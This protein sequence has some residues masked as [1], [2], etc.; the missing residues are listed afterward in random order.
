MRVV[1]FGLILLTS[2][3]LAKEGSSVLYLLQAEEWAQAFEAYDQRKITLG[4]HDFDQLQQM[5]LA[6]LEKSARS[7][8]PTEQ[9]TSLFGSSIAG[10][11]ASIDILE[12]GI[13]SP[14][15]ETQMAALQFLGHLQDDRCEELFT[16][17]MSSD[18]FFTRMEAAHQLCLR[19][20]HTA[21]GQIESLMYKVPPPMRSFF[22]PFFA[23]LGTHDAIVLLKGMMDDPLHIVRVEA[24][25]SAAR[26]GR[27]D[28]LPAIRRLATHLNTAEQEACAFAFGTLK[29][30]Q[31]IPLLQ[32]LK[33]SHS[34]GVQLASLLA[35]FK[36]G[37]V[38]AKKEIETRA[39]EHD[40]FAIALLGEIPGSEGK[41]RPLLYSSD[42]QVRFNATL[43]L[44]QRKDPTVIPS[45]MSFLIRDSRD[46][47][48]Q[49]QFSLGNSLMA[50]KTIPSAK[51]HAKESPY[52]IF[53]LSLNL[54]EHLLQDALELPPEAFLKVA[55]SLFESK[56]TDLIPR[57]I[58]LMENLQ[59]EEAIALLKEGAQLTGA[60]LTRS[61]C[62][63]ALYRVTKEEIYKS[64][65]LQW[66]SLKQQTEIIRFRPQLPWTV[67]FSDQRTPFEL[68]PEENSRLLID[69][70]QTLA[71]SQ[72][73]DAID[74]LLEALRKGNSSN[75]PLLAGLLIQAIQ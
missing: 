2:P 46:L 65:L 56:Q 44:L 29:D 8:S 68:T 51:Q 61:Y 32:R 15:P 48:F 50:W 34:P 49:P 7:S 21:T 14:H 75:R 9:L 20:A 30:A 26:F 55:R 24:I 36:L 45:L 59:T 66:I 42:P 47:G 3:L 37:D 25:L 74:I 13:T 64:A 73:A 28:L 63:L 18:F 41:L 10:V 72:E 27:D 4:K 62:H 1:F 53:T 40:L 12:A 6:I 57:L 5:A 43:A 70:Y 71:L 69:C 54:R 22:A 11:S 58:H 67:R 33:T 35:L 60:P 52:D 38:G 31:S 39:E 16:R 19:K 17:A 23:E